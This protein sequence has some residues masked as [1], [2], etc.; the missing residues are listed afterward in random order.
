MF[1]SLFP[2]VFINNQITIFTNY[3]ELTNCALRIVLMLRFKIIRYQR[4]ILV[5]EKKKD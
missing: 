5:T 4:I 1:V 3:Y 2:T